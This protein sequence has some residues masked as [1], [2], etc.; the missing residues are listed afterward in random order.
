ML[1]RSCHGTYHQMSEKHLDLYIDEFS[2]RRSY[3]PADTI[4]QIESVTA[5]TDAKLLTYWMLMGPPEAPQPAK[6]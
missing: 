6:L 4:N 1:R 3:Q 2:G 5:G